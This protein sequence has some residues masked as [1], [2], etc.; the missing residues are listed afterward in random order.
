MQEENIECLVWI[1]VNNLTERGHGSSFLI[2]SNF[3]VIKEAKLLVD[4]ENGKEEVK[5]GGEQNE[6]NTIIW[7]NENQ[8]PE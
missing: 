8:E 7:E 5:A 4:Q 1:Q 2:A 3:S 6:C